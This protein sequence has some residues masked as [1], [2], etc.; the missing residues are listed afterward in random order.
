MMSLCGTQSSQSE[1]YVIKEQT[2]AMIEVLCVGG[3]MKQ[4][5]VQYTKYGRKVMR[6]IFFYP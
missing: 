3:K 4:W 1:Y 2:F 6:L 5:N